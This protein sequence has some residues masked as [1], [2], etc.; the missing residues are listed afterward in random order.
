[1]KNLDNV[2]LPSDQE[3]F[4]LKVWPSEAPEGEDKS[5]AAPASGARVTTADA[6]TEEKPQVRLIN[7]DSTKYLRF[8]F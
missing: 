2:P 6:V 4:F 7:G 3:D 5:T 1:M 8:W